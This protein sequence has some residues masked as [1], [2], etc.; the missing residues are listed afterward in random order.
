MTIA[1]KIFSWIFGSIVLLLLSTSVLF[2]QEDDEDYYEQLLTKE[3]EVE[4]PVY[5]PVISLGTG[6]IRY[7]GDIRYPNKNPVMGNMGYKFN[8]S[9]LFG[10]QNFFKLN[11]YLMYGNVEGHDYS[12][13]QRMQ[14]DLSFLTSDENG[15]PIYHNSSFRTEFFELGITVEYG[16]GHWIGKSKRFRPFISAGISPFPFTPKGDIK[17]SVTGGSDD[18]YYFWNDGTMRNLHESTPDHSLAKII[19]FDKEW[20]TDLS[21]ADYHGLGKFSQTTIAIPVEIGFDFY[22]SYRVNLRIAT[23]LHYTF[24]DMLDNY[25]EKA[26]N[27]YVLKGN[28]RNDMF[29]FTN[30]SFS[31]DMFSDPEM[32][33]VDM[34]FAELEDVDYEVMFADQDMDG[35]F[36]RLDEC[37]DTPIGVEVDSVGCP[38]D[39]DGDGVPDFMD[40]E[41]NTPPGSIVDDRGVQLSADVLAQMY[42]R[43]TAV[44]REEVQLMPVAP[45]WTRSI[46]FAPG[47]IPQKFRRFDIDGDGYIAFEEL[48]KAIEQFFDG[49]LDFSTEDIYELNNFFFSQ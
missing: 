47:E 25:N 38:L 6:V 8:V 17:Y 10:K 1:E 27:R 9:T 22:L 12:I 15:L 42:E 2:A 30:F 39:M 3:V 32:M 28:G 19:N 43:P 16:F 23:S 37:P 46:A 31:F 44:R 29:M 13:S 18:Y 33:K 7:L 40:D 36:D 20:E 5:K 21:K 26:A 45:I 11:F 48:L 35:I 49:A 4:N 14:S 34:L 41:P 24:T